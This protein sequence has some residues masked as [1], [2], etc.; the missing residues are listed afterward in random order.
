[1]CI[2]DR[3]ISRFL[4]EI[5]IL[6]H[7]L[8]TLIPAPKLGNSFAPSTS[9]RSGWPHSSSGAPSSS[10]TIS[11]RSGWHHTSSGISTNQ[12]Q[13]QSRTN[14]MNN[15]SHTI[16][17]PLLKALKLAASFNQALV[18]P[19]HF[20]MNNLGTTDASWLFL[21]IIHYACSI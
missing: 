18:L 16:T 17:Q 21:N 3:H 14:L 4:R 11:T 2:R 1:M 19:P 7:A 10:S 9:T 13:I 6:K 8:Q 20:L 12:L 5:F 15:A